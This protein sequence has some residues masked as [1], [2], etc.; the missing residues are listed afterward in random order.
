MAIKAG[1]HRGAEALCPQSDQQHGGDMTAKLGLA[2]GTGGARGWCHIGV[3]RALDEMG[4]RPDV[5]AGSSMGALVGAA[6]AGGALDALEDWARA[7]TPRRV[8]SL[9][10]MRLTGGG[11]VGGTSIAKMLEEIGLDCRIED[12]SLPF[13]AVAADLSS[14]Q[15]VWLQEGPLASATRASVAIPGILSPVCI[16]G[17][18]LIDGGVVNPVPITPFD[19]RRCPGGCCREPE[20]RHRRAVSGRRG[21]IGRDC[22]ISQRWST[23]F[24]RNC[25]M[26]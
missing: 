19:C 26:R 14:G 11:L 15:E 25:R 3:L 22:R 16:D 24:Q 5:V 4:V 13:I 17:R 12:L 7:L 8:W 21:R 9:I 18:W 23:K 20:C 1:K 2:L 6:Y 10:D